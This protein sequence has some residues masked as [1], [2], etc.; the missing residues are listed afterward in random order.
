MENSFDVIKVDPDGTLIW[1]EAAETVGDAKLRV[2]EL[3]AG[4]PGE[5]FVF[6]QTT[7]EMVALFYPRTEAEQ[8]C[9]MS[10]D[11]PEQCGSN[12]PVDESAAALSLSEVM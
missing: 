4:S 10:A 8:L 2:R 11:E 7:R 9:L 12:A 5:Y 1:V 3:I 6:D